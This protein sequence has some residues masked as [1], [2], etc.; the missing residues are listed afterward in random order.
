MKRY[1]FFWSNAYGPL[2]GEFP[3]DETPARHSKIWINKKV[4]LII[5]CIIYEI[6]E[7]NSKYQRIECISDTTYNNIGGQLLYDYLV[8][9]GFRK[10]Y[11]G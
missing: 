11:E 2:Y 5:T 7:D 1:L 4:K 6:S 3:F 9:E 10:T 8:K